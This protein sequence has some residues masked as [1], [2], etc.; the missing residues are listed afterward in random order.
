MIYIVYQKDSIRLVET[1]RNEYLCHMEL[2][3]GFRILVAWTDKT[4]NSAW[5]A[6]SILLSRLAGQ[7]WG[8]GF[9][10]FE[11]SKIWR[12][13]HVQYGKGIIFRQSHQNLQSDQWLTP[14]VCICL[15]EVIKKMM[16]P[17]KAQITINSIHIKRVVKE[18][19]LGFLET[20]SCSK[21]SSVLLFILNCSSQC[22]THPGCFFALINPFRITITMGLSVEMLLIK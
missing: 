9:R 7:F 3:S 12:W 17:I 19:V 2:K 20:N 21:M 18:Q 8:G 16:T 6:C 14:L 11:I 5:L 1:F 15:P 13:F 22:H 4:P 10:S